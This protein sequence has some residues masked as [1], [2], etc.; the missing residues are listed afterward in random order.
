MITAVET[1]AVV[2]EKHTVGVCT[3]A[4]WRM[5]C[6]IVAVAID[7]VGRGAMCA[8]YYIECIKNLSRPSS[9]KRPSEYVS[10]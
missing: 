7:E 10:M 9:S 5:T 6:V 8:R 4:L 2:G 3:G 1:A